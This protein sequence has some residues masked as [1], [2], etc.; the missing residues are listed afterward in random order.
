MAEVSSASSANPAPFPGS[1]REVVLDAT[2]PGAG[3][4]HIPSLP[5][6]NPASS[7]LCGCKL[8]VLER[9]DACRYSET[10]PA[11]MRCP[12][13]FWMGA[14]G[15]SQEFV[16]IQS[17]PTCCLL[18]PYSC[19]TALA[20]E[21]EHRTGGKLFHE[22][23]PTYTMD[24]KVPFGLRQPGWFTKPSLVVLDPSRIH[25]ETTETEATICCSFVVS[26]RLQ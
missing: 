17:C 16:S 15:F 12:Q 5:G 25:T 10:P 13:R 11:E 2:L 3:Q 26:H 1:V 19:A 14:A 23:T 9:R 4:G 18:A 8:H 24:G 21:R 22:A 7:P 20:T 6:A